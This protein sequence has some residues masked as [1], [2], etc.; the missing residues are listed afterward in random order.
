ML[1][2]QTNSGEINSLLSLYYNIYKGGIIMSEE[3]HKQCKI[4]NKEFKNSG[5]LG[6]H[7]REH[8]ITTK[9]YFDK[10]LKREDDGHCKTCGKETTFNTLN[11]G[12]G[13][14]C[15]RPCRNNDKE[16][17]NDVTEKTKELYKNNPEKRLKEKLKRKR[18]NEENPEIYKRAKE[19]EMQT[20]NANPEI[21]KRAG[22]KG[23]KTK[24]DNPEILKESARKLSITKRNTY[25]QL[26]DETCEIPYYL[27][28]IHHPEK[29][30]IKIGRSGNPENRLGGIINDFG[31]CKI[32]HT[33]Q[34]K[35]NKICPL[36]TFL[37]NKFNEYCR[38]Q[39]TGSGR[40]EWFDECILEEVL[41]LLG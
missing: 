7:L 40:T 12:Y 21:M 11:R 20:K 37:H 39:P 4:C 36:E 25:N 33:I 31:S 29:S 26:I 15:S 22:K 5:S 28:I 14:Y 18:T 16:L 27:Y 17:T 24:Q 2:H 23:S 1:Q 13:T 6:C 8:K 34:D 19:K 9:T 30:I 35:Y 41:L 38:V 10:F 32:I 3:I